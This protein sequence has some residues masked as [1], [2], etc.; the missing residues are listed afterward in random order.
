[1]A[2]PTP[3]P[4]KRGLVRRLRE[5]SGVVSTAIGGI[6]QTFAPDKAKYPF[7]TYN[8]VTAPNQFAWGST[9]I[10]AMFDVFAWS[11]N[12]VEAENLDALIATA[13]HNAPLD[14]G[15]QSLLQCRRMGATPTG[16]TTDGTGRKV[17]QIGGSYAIWTSHPDG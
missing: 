2:V 15:E 3:S 6:H 5:S 1:M 16:S 14:V 10:R 12:S 7:I 4:I 9:E 13:L 8:L 11:E 17:Y